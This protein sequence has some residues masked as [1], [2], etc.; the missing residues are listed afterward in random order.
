MKCILTFLSN[1]AAAITALATVVI[2]AFTV[3]MW[4]V[5]HRI[6][7]ATLKRDREMTEL[8]MNIM[9]TIL[10]SG[11]TVGLPDLS[12]R[13]IAEMKDKL[14]HLFTEPKPK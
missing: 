12:I 11:R 1:N 4:L 7:Q 14:R 13:L 5:S 3:L 2:A 9:A 8:Y 10:V 6:H